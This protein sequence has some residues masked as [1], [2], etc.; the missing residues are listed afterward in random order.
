MLC[1]VSSQSVTRVL[2]FNCTG[3]RDSRK[4]LAPLA[5]RKKML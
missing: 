3:E 4:L 5:V 1:F 2:I